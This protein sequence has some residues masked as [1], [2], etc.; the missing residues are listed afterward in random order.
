M[1]CL[2]IVDCDDDAIIL[3]YPN[4]KSIDQI[5]N[6]K[7]ISF[8]IYIDKNEIDKVKG[9]SILYSLNYNVDTFFVM[10]VVK[11]KIIFT[12]DGLLLF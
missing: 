9:I 11:H 1:I 3:K 12:N 6:K 2:K 8:H 5:L 7:I 4:V 10:D